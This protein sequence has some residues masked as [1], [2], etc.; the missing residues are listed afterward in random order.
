[1]MGRRQ[2]LHVVRLYRQGNDCFSSAHRVHTPRQNALGDK[3]VP[4]LFDP[5][6]ELLRSQPARARFDRSA[7]DGFPHVLRT[8]LDVSAMLAHYF[9]QMAGG[10]FT[11]HGE[12]IL[13]MFS[14]GYHYSLHSA[15]E[16]GNATSVGDQAAAT[17]GAICVMSATEEWHAA[18]AS[19]TVGS[20]AE[21]RPSARIA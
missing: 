3:I 7:G 12:N 1:M 14:L 5:D 10:V 11:E 9:E 16:L 13:R 8:V 20:N 6:H 21:P 15:E 19:R 4:D 18:S 17:K 2:L